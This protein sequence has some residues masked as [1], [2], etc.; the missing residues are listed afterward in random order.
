LIL[1]VPA[2][3]W[4]PGVGGVSSVYL[5]VMSEMQGRRGLQ[6]LPDLNYHNL[7]KMYLHLYPHKKYITRYSDKNKQNAI[8]LIVNSFWCCI[9]GAVS[10]KANVAEFSSL[11]FNKNSLT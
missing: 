3:A 4:L 7:P 10:G 5:C 8:T 6:G 9:D 2:I 1:L 11:T